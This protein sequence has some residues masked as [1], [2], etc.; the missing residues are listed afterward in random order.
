MKFG[1]QAP[2]YTLLQ[3]KNH[4]PAK[5]DQKVEFYSKREIGLISQ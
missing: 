1:Q 4:F 5:E 3:E 2:Y